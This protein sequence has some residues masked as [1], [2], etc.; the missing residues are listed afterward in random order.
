[1]N[2]RIFGTCI[3]SHNEICCYLQFCATLISFGELLSFDHFIFSI[4]YVLGVLSERVLTAGSYL[5]E[6]DDVFIFFI[7]PKIQEYIEFSWRA[8]P[9]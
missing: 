5:G 4:M 1:M 6:R 2:L 8:N 7:Q 9:I 3:F